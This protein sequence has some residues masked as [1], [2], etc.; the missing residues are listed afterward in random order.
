[1]HLSPGG[2]S[3]T[4]SS[5]DEQMNARFFSGGQMLP[6]RLQRAQVERSQVVGVG[7]VKEDFP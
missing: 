2:A 7:A 1:M 6:Y 4:A 3:Q 5:V